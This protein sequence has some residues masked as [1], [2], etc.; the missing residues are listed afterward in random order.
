MFS[1]INQSTM[2]TENASNLSTISLSANNIYNLSTAVPAYLL[3]T[4]SS[5]LLTP[6]SSNTITKLISK[7][8]PKTKTDP[9]E[10]EIV[11][12]NPSTDPQY[13]QNL[14][15][16]QYLSLLITSKDISPNNQKLKQKQPLISNISPATISNDKFLAAIFSFELKETI[17]V[18]LFKLITVIYIDAKVNG[19][20]IKLILDSHQV[21]H[22]A[23]THIITADRATKTPISKINNLSIKVNGI[24]VPIKVLVME[25]IQYQALVENDWLFKTN[26][27]LD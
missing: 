11:N 10:L 2:A 5:N 22:A 6:T 19:H 23:S 17:P 8:N 18:L 15:V 16:Q 25:A 9:T 14:N 3:A 27:T 12:G 4:V 21:D 13:T 20:A 26:A 7:Q 1:I 24:I